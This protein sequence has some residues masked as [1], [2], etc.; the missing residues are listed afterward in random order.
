MACP[1]SGEGQLRKI[2]FH[3]RP[4]TKPAAS[5]PHGVETVSGSSDE[6]P[7]DYEVIFGVDW[8]RETEFLESALEKH[9]DREVKS[10]FEPPAGLR[11]V[12]RDFSAH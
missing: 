11:L 1:P 2:I 7:V 8:K 6:Y 3:Q 5:R 10:M 12:E 9:A 4:K